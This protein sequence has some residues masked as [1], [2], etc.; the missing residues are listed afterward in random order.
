MSARLPTVDQTNF[1]RFTLTDIVPV[2]EGGKFPAAGVTGEVIP[3]SVTAFR[4]GHDSLGVDIRF[5]DPTGLECGPYPM[6]SGDDPDRYEVLFQPDTEGYWSFTITAWGDPW[7]T[8]HHQA[9]IKIPA[10]LDTDL[11][12]TE[13]AQLLQLIAMHPKTPPDQS[14]VLQS[15]IVTVLNTSL[16]ASVRLAAATDSAVMDIA[17]ANPIR[18]SPTSS[19][20]WPLLVERSRALVGSWYEFFPRS[21]GATLDPPRSGTFASAARRLPH[22]AAMGFDVVYLPPIHPIGAIN[23]KGR[24]NTLTP[25]KH[26]PGSP[27]AIGSKDG[28]HDCIHPDLG[29]VGDFKEFVKTAHK[30]GLEIAL[31]LALQSSPDHPWVKAH[32]EWFT[33]RADG[34]IAFAENPPKKY[35]DVYPLNFDNDPEGLYAEVERV[36]RYWIDL[37]IEIFRVDN[38][39][40]K[41]VWVWNRLI[42]AINATHPQVIFLA[43]A[44]TRAPM[45]RALAEQGFQQSYTYFTWKTSKQEIE[46]YFAQIAGP[47]SAYMR[48]NVFTNTPDILH[49]YLQSGIPAAFAIRA[50]LAATLSPTYGI[51]SGFELYEHV[52]LRPGSEEYLDS[53]K[54]E[55]RPRDWERALQQGRTLAPYLTRLN[56]IRRDNSA[57]Q[58][59]RSLSFHATDSPDII[60]YSKRDHSNVVL[61][62]CNLDP[63]HE[64]STT[65]HWNMPVLGLDWDSEFSVHEELTHS[66]WRW[67]PHTFVRLN[68]PEN[69]AHIARVSSPVKPQAVFSRKTLP[70][71]TA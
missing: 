7:N 64:H 36:V 59:L 46:E 31:D 67:S 4:E 16:P 3:F 37:G 61:V 53:E 20:P 43:E 54:F 24:N 55:Y 47:M 57:L 71:F 19:G 70:R 50:T 33:T 42:H 21:E 58:S 34:S 40:T 17:Q 69:V 25:G 52:S 60:A 65:V 12:F 49:E 32:P 35:Q 51:Y 26:D 1:Q 13:G 30:E 44:L 18:E 68:P 8:W 66:S 28:G 5:T 11:E 2:V 9:S 6:Q 27:W 29:T 56:Q 22:I 23:R 15:A 41:P 62:V 39:H 45:M 38:P 10:G 63:N 48:P 14:A